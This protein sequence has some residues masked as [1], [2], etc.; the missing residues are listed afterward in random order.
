MSI[1]FDDIVFGP[2]KSRRFGVSLGIN[3]LPTTTK[4]CSF[5]CIYCECGWTDGT[6]G[7]KEKLFSRE[8]IAKAMEEKLPLLKE[9]GLSPD[10]I[11]F[12]GNGEPTIHPQFAEIMEDTIAFRDKYFPQAKITVL[13]NATMLPRPHVKEALLKADNNILKLDAGSQTMFN[14]INR[15][16]SPLQI[17]EIVKHLESFKGNLV[18]QTL[19]LRGRYHN[20]TIDNTSPQELSIWLEHLKRIKPKSVMLYSLDRETPAKELIKVSLDEMETIAQRVRQLG[21]TANIY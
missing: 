7:K 1:L 20:E 4:Y 17:E 6:E 14:R 16:M 15:P 13:S 18:I 11:T 5:D 9:Q 21:I 19:F 12:A 10:S 3:L 2:I 8:H